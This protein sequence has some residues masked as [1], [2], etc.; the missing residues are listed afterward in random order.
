[1]KNF[2]SGQYIQTLGSRTANTRKIIHYLYQ[3]PIIDAA[4]ITEIAEISVSSAYKFIG[5][6]VGFGI[7]EEIAGGK[8]GK[9][10]MFMAYLNLFK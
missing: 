6:L 5:D 7:L 10:Y 9:Q 3:R 8:R 2:Q 4:K 1:M